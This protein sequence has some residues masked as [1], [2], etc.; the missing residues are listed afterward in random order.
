MFVIFLDESV[1][2]AAKVKRDFKKMTL[3]YDQEIAKF[4]AKGFDKEAPKRLTKL[5]V[6]EYFDAAKENF[7]GA[8]KDDL[9]NADN[10]MCRIITSA[11][12]KGKSDKH[13]QKLEQMKAEFLEKPVRDV[14]KEAKKEVENENIRRM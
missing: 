4:N 6:D 11:I 3:S 7:P 13:I 14:E 9:I 2:I 12:A 5:A 1:I 10:C 8:K